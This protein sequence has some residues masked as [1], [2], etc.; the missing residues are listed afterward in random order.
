MRGTGRAVSKGG[1][2]SHTGGRESEPNE[3]HTRPDPQ[4]S[5]S[6]GPELPLRE[7]DEESE[8]EDDEPPGLDDAASTV[9]YGEDD[10]SHDFLADSDSED[11]SGDSSPAN[12][13]EEWKTRQDQSCLECMDG[14]LHWHP[15][16]LGNEIVLDDPE[17]KGGDASPAGPLEIHLSREMSKLYVSDELT[18]PAVG[19]DGH[20]VVQLYPSG[21]KRTVVERA[22][23]IL[24]IDEARANEAAV[25]RAMLDELTRWHQLQA[26]ERMPKKLATNLIDAR[27]VLTWKEVNGKRTIQ[28]R[29]VVRGFKDTQAEQLSTFAGTRRGGANA[30]STAWPPTTAGAPSAQT[31][32]KLTVAVPP[33]RKMRR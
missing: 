15:D 16:V 23:N 33:S 30:S 26:F 2:A 20:Y 4:A 25:N 13:S 18:L 10:R 24:S 7:D 14:F 32:A 19:H 3:D 12:A 21:I 5:S 8:D 9:D 17:A 11:E 6:G 27:W 28:A 29:L 22:N 1:D 31:C